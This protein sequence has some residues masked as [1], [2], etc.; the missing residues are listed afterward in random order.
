M[1]VTGCLL[2]A[3]M[4]LCVIVP[5]KGF[6]VGKER[7][8]FAL[9]HDARTRLTTATAQRVIEAA[10]DAGITTRVVTDDAAV[11][12]L[13][14]GLG[15]EP[16]PDPG[17]GLNAAIAAGLVGLDRWMIV[18]G[19]L[20]LLDAATLSTIA[21]EIRQGQ[22]VL[23]PA[24]DGGTNVLG[25]RGHLAPAYGRGS[26]H[27]HLAQAARHPHRIIV[28]PST[29]VEIDTPSDLTAAARLPGGTWLEQFLS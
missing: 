22:W 10:R 26:F 9:S 4:S 2:S 3:P 11:C 14:A 20:P 16:V 8:S 6:T 1:V 12:D 28:G 7:L 15:A 21:S 23:A 18:H 25:G 17:S 13:A 27:R 24:L 5:L 29:A 19:D